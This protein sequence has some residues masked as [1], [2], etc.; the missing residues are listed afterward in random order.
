M[1]DDGKLT[2]QLRPEEHAFIRNERILCQLDFAYALRFIVQISDG[3]GLFYLDN[4]WDSQKL[5]LARLGQLEE[6]NIAQAQRGEPCDGMLI[7]DHKGGRQLGHTPSAV[8]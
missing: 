2:R 5:L 6:Q 8:L 7:A 4:L 1:G 3:G